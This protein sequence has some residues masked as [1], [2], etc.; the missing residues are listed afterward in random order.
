MSNYNKQT[1]KNGQVLTAECLNRMEDGIF[2]ACLTCP[3]LTTEGR[4]ADAAA[5]GAEFSEY[6]LGESVRHA[7]DVNTELTR[8]YFRITSA[9]KNGPFYHG[10]GHIRAYNATEVVQNIIQ[11]TGGQELIRRST[12]GGATWVEEW[13]NPP[14][15]L[16]E[17]YRTTKRYQG[18]PVYMKAIECGDAPKSSGK[19]VSHGISNCRAINCYGTTSA[20]LSLPYHASTGNYHIYVSGHSTAIS[21]YSNYDNTATGLIVVMEYYKSTD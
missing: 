1:F 5:V 6:G 15:N 14:L 10:A 13:I 12:D 9:T 19:S 4:A 3:D 2:D 18:K 21:I 11:T 17:E 16:G 20:G 8:G 7:G